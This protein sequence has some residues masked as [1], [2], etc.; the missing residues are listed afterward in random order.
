MRKRGAKRRILAIDPTTR[1]FG[2]VV[3]EGADRLIDWGLRD[4][5]EDKARRTI[6]K[7]DDLLRLYR[8]SLLV[9]EDTEDPT[10]RRSPRIMQTI[11][12]IVDFALEKRLRVR[13]FAPSKVR[14]CFVRSG[15]TTKHQI[16]GVISG[17]F[18]ELA[19]YRPPRRKLWMS[20]DD[21]MAIFDAAALAATFFAWCE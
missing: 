10:S 20:E 18:P 11:R 6:E 15:A 9:V 19:P 14:A 21:R 2:F 16:A 8:P 7:L 3:F 13:A 17:R 12:S 5:R 4:I 1:G